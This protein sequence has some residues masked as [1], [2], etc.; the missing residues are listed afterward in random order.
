MQ[1]ASGSVYGS[2]VGRR[3]FQDARFGT[4]DV[5]I[6][7]HMTTCLIEAQALAVCNQNGGDA[8]DELGNRLKLFGHLCVRISRV[9]HVA[10][11]PK[12]GDIRRRFGNPAIQR[13][14]LSGNI[15]GK[16]K[17]Q[18]AEKNHRDQYR[19]GQVEAVFH[20]VSAAL[21]PHSVH[22]RTVSAVRFVEFS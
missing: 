2:D 9:E 16:G 4:V 10:N 20:F 11:A 17:P 12:L 6:A 7:R 13:S 22:L 15:H 14:S 8:R 3:P 18:T 21:F 19:H 1:W 5:H